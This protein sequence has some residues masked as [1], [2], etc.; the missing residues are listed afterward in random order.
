MRKRRV[1][2]EWLRQTRLVE[3]EKKRNDKIQ[4]DKSLAKVLALERNRSEVVVAKKVVRKEMTSAELDQEFRELN[5]AQMRVNTRAAVDH[6]V[7][8]E[9]SKKRETEKS[10]TPGVRMMREEEAG[11]SSRLPPVSDILSAKTRGA[12][13]VENEKNITMKKGKKVISVPAPIVEEMEV[14]SGG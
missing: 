8:A 7:G 3:K 2:E 11:E 5:A 1:R 9:V 13:A 10:R 12:G 4:F 6:I 14:G